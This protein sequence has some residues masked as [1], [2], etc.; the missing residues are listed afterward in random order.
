[1][2]QSLL[3]TKLGAPPIRGGLVSRPRLSGFVNAGLHRKLTLVSAPAGFGK[4]TLLSEWAA[5]CAWPVAWLSLD[6]GD[7]DPAR[8]W[9]YFIAALQTVHPKMGESALDELLSPQPPR[10]ELLLTELINEMTEQRE[11]WALVLD[12]YHVIEDRPV[13]DGLTFLLEHLPPK[14]HLVI[15]SRTDPP[16]PLARLRGQAEL[17]ELRAADLRFTPE[18]AAMFFNEA[19]SLSLPEE[20][21]TALERRTEGWIAGLQLAAISM[22]GQDREGISSLISTITG[23]HR[24]IL[25]YLTEE[26]LQRQPEHIQSFLLQTSILDGLCGPLCDAV[27]GQRDGQQT[28]EQLERANLF[29]VPL[30]SQRRWYRYHHLFADL[31]RSRL[32]QTMDDLVPTLHHRA[33]EW[34]E[35]SGLIFEAANQALETGDAQR[36]ARLVEKN[37]LTMLGH[38]E[39][40]TLARWLGA[41]P[42]DEL[43]TRPWLCI[44]RAWVL[45]YTARFD[46]VWELLCIAEEGLAAL[47]ADT[48]ARRIT[49]HATAIRAYV[50]WIQGQGSRAVELAREALDQL[51]REDLLV[52]GH[53]ATTLGSALTVVGEFDAAEQAF[54]DAVDTGRMLGVTHVGSMAY[55]GWIHLLILKGHLHRAAELCWETLR[56]AD[57]SAIQTGRRLPAMGNIYALLSTIAQEW[58]DLENAAHLAEQGLELGKQWSQV[59]TLTVNYVYL[60]AALRAI[61]DFDGALAAVREARRIATGVSSWFE[62]IVGVEEVRVHLAQGNLAFVSRWARDSGASLERSV[63]AESYE[64]HQILAQVLAAQGKHDEALA[65]LEQMAKT[66]EAMGAG[67]YLIKALTLQALALQALGRQSQAVSVLERALSLAEPEG[68]V[69]VFVNGGA[70]MI[71]LLQQAAARGTS[72]EYVGRLLIA[73]GKRPPLLNRTRIP[74]TALRSRAPHLLVEPLTAR[75]MEVLRLLAAGLSNS[76]IAETLVIA[77]GT[78]K[79]HLKNIYGKLDVHS[80]IQA[81]TRAKELGLL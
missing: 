32:E 77:T 44:A 70:P 41:L 39:L 9:T 76:E 61:G 80:R 27:T 36:V 58:H 7:N 42:G 16:L 40:Q 47:G 49:G 59:D 3:T 81:S 66:V 17:T 24:Y 48:E 60:S 4:T 57:E 78:V 8:F 11:P 71:E 20:D 15:A 6:G 26:V 52:R 72:I 18:E 28:L 51:P 14:A 35:E 55:A 33:S 74:R 73:M 25:D 13:H 12:D 21:V 29:I 79:N 5:N 34:Y 31:L 64:G 68:Y 23:S 75:E 53:A 69:Q 50:A 65:L 37:A 30:D 10:I 67:G 22:Q 19:M 43:H 63:E 54:T 1:M 2:R 38:A 45:A 56:L 46:Q 62:N